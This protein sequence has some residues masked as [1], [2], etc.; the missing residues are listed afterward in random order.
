VTATE[1]PATFDAFHPWG[2]L[3]IKVTQTACE[4]GPAGTLESKPPVG[5]VPH[6]E[7]GTRATTM[8]PAA[9]PAGVPGGVVAVLLLDV[10]TVVAEELVVVAPT[11]LLVVLAPMLLVRLEVDEARVPLLAL[12][13]VGPVDPRLVLDDETAVYVPVLL[14]GLLVALVEAVLLPAPGVITAATLSFGESPGSAAHAKNWMTRSTKAACLT[15]RRR[16]IGGPFS[17]GGRGRDCACGVSA[18]S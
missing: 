2:T 9:H 16:R 1:Q 8:A 4:S 7:L 18:Y 15:R 3:P 12:D 6:E 11:L 5:V 10:V 17:F 14:P 13:V